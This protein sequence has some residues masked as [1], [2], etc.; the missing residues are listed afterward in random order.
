M[1]GTISSKAMRFFALE[2]V[3]QLFW[4]EAADFV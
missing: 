4:A 1:C 3:T 2:V